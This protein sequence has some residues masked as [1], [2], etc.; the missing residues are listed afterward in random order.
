M[1]WGELKKAEQNYSAALRKVERARAE[2][3]VARKKRAEAFRNS[4]RKHRKIKFKGLYE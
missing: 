4:A 2:L 3:A 1:A